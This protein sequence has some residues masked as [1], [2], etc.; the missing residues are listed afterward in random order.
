[1]NETLRVDLIGG[2]R[3]PEALL[4]ARARRD[5]G[6]L[7]DEDFQR[8]VDSAVR[9][10]IAKEE[11][12]HLPVVTDGEYRRHNFQESFG[13][14]VTGF[15]AAPYVYTGAAARPS[16]W[17][18]GRIETGVSAPGPAILN[19]LPVKERLRLVR[20]PILEE[21]R[22]SSSI[23]TVPVKLT[24][25]GPDRISQRFEWES[26]QAVYPD[27]DAFLEDVVAIERQM[28]ADVVAA[29]CSYVQIDA[30]G[31]TAY[32]DPPSLERIRARGEDPSANLQ[33]S[34]RA[35][36]AIIAGFPGVTF[37]LHVCRGNGP[38]WHRE[39]HYDAIAEQLFTGL[40][41]DRLLLE[42]DTERAGSFEPLRFIPKGKIAVLGLV[43]TKLSRV[44]TEEELSRRIEG[45]ARF[46]PLEQL[47]LSPQC[48]FGGLVGEDEQWRKIDAIVATAKRVWG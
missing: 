2:M 1:L 19:R 29:G 16:T 12:H 33:R 28:I 43:S 13:G 3:R 47:A 34:I 9:D 24:L 36:N 35:E 42:Y 22:F 23:A 21:Y 45:A 20:N 30:P 27:M 39:G 18:P 41:H 4:E 14:A 40:N 46:L 6:E 26:S 37:G 44:E 31:F 8:T 10:L 25:I 11:A 7:P 15:D 32:V 38:G 5:R 17:Q 48:G